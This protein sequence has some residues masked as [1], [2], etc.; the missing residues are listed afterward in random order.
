MTALPYV[1][2]A[3]EVTATNVLQPLGISMQSELHDF[4]T[5]YI[6]PTRVQSKRVPSNIGKEGQSCDGSSHARGHVRTLLASLSLLEAMEQLR[7]VCQ[8]ACNG[9]AS[10][11]LRM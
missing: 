10:S 5:Q 8:L 1:I 9:F 6:S 4:D 3:W 7:V 11:I 2:V